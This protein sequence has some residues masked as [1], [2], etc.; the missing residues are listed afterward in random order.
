M[1]GSQAPQRSWIRFPIFVILVF[2]T[3]YLFTIKFTASYI[4]ILFLYFLLDAYHQEW[5]KFY[6]RGKKGLNLFE[7]NIVEHTLFTNCITK[8]VH[9]LIN[10]KCQLSPVIFLSSNSSNKMPT[11]TALLQITRKTKKKIGFPLTG[12]VN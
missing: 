2:N 3:I 5:I 12:K 10:A 11:T 4:S 1:D 8:I 9:P 6:Y 7:P